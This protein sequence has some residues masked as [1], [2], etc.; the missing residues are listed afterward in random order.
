MTQVLLLIELLNLRTTSEI[1]VQNSSCALGVVRRSAVP[2]MA[3][4]DDDIA[5]LR[6]QN[7]LIWVSEGRISQ[8][9]RWRVGSVMRAGNEP[10]RAIV[11]S[12]IIQQPERV[13][14]LIV[15]GNFK[16]APIRM[17]TL[18]SLSG[19]GVAR[20]QRRQLEIVFSRHERSRLEFLASG[21][22]PKR[23]SLYS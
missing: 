6:L 22:S 3:I 16:S 18:M 10:S 12:E 15:S 23:R 11:R 2:R 17:K 7:D 1:S 19:K 5:R 21:K 14:D 13:A 4:H 8:F 9:I 20:V